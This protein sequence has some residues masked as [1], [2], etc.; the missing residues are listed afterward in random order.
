MKERTG[1][2]Y[3]NT[4]EFYSFDTHE[5]TI[6]YKPEEE[7]DQTIA[8]G[9]GGGDKGIVG[10]FADLLQGTYNGNCLSDVTVSCENHLIAFAAEES[11][12]CGTVV[13]MDEFV[14]RCRKNANSL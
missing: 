5:T 10:T 8:G 12:L 7:M 4:L 6:I 1:Q 13:D 9:H 11:R 14:E 3:K 2:T